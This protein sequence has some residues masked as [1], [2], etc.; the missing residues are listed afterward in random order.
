LYLICQ[1]TL[2]RDPKITFRDLE[3]GRDH[4]LRC[5]AVVHKKSITFTRYAQALVNEKNTNTQDQA[6]TAKVKLEL[7][8]KK[9]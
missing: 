7:L 2:L 6:T 9:F 4:S 1:A 3:W 5:P 8:T